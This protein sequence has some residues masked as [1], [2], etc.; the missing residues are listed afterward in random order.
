MD[1]MDE[2]RKL[3]AKMKAF[4]DFQDP[5]DLVYGKI[6]QDDN[7][8]YR[9]IFAKNPSLSPEEVDYLK[10]SMIMTAFQRSVY[11]LGSIEMVLKT[12]SIQSLFDPNSR[13]ILSVIVDELKKEEEKKNKTQNLLA[14]LAEEHPQNQEN[15]EKLHRRL[16]GLE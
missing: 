4:R 12:L 11:E 8:D 16:M 7:G 5:P 1:E 13:E 6:Y 3:Y 9:M 2:Q 14:K 15:K 10:R